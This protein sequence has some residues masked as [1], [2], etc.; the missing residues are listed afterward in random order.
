MEQQIKI[1]RTLEQLAELD[2][3]LEDKDLVAYDTETTGVEKDSKIIGYSI[4]AETHLGWYVILSYWDVEK[5][6]LIDLETRE[7]TKA[8]LMKLKTKSLI[9]HNAVFDCMMTENNWDVS[10]I[11]S[12]HVDTMILAHLVDEN[13]SN[14]LKELGISVFGQDATKEQKEM[15]E[16]VSK[17]GGLLT[18][19]K[20]EL[21]KADAELIARYGAKDAILTLNILFHEFS[22]LQ[23]EGLVDFL[24]EES[25][26]LLRG[27]TY[28]LNTVGLK[29]DMEKLENLKHLLQAECLEAQSFIYSEID[30]AVKQDYPGT[31][32]AKTFNIGS[33]KQ[34]S[35]LLFHKLGNTFATLT[36]EGKEVC[37]ALGFNKLP[38]SDAD[39]RQFLRECASAKGHLYKQAAFNHKT[40]KLGRPKKIG[41]PW[42]Y[43]ACGKETLA[44]LA[45]RYKWVETFLKYAK[46]KK[47]LSTYVEG[48]QSRM[49]YGIIRPSFLQNVVPSGRYASRNPNF[50][51]L[52]RDDKRINACIVSR[53]GKVFVGC[54][55]PQ[56]EPRV[57]ASFSGDKRLLDCFARGEDF[58]SVI[59]MY[60]F[61]KSD[62]VPL[63]EGHPDAFGTKYKTLRQIAKV[64]A[65]SATYGTTAP[66]MAMSIE[67]DTKISK[68]TQE[69]QEIIDNYFE[70]FPAVKQFMNASHQE[71]METGK[72]SS[73]FGRVR[74]IP[75]AKEIKQLFKNVPHSELSYEYR[76]LLNLAVN[77]RIQGTGGSIMNRS[78][79]AFLNKC[80]ELEDKN[81]AWKDV[82]IVLQ[83][84]D[85]LIAEGPENLGSEI[86]EVM[87][88]A[89]SNTVKLPGVALPC[90]PKIAYNLADLK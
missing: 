67:K 87:A 12:V 78:S 30:Q 47:L 81:P 9:M 27:T 59:G 20:Y 84:H 31:S 90:E 35:W 74:R 68:T 56:L 2:K 50:Q 14:A 76:N 58:Y 39:K 75:K 16:S 45:P 54:D 60:A 42:I 32:K 25:M 34:L 41:D 43:L 17:N 4:C 86:V 6:K 57:F 21:Y 51:N 73:L 40:K 46:N 5:K 62:A 64:I 3:Y 83:K 36:D 18:K 44:K 52:P 85:E 28:Q 1:V 71:A 61:A 88:D 82:K 26:P 89:M 70:T 66:K 10:L 22:K 15:K 55:Y 37:K 19:D 24:F 8:L 80:K 72:V 33:S 65:L 77:Y 53:P 69:A 29:V 79:I 48:I 13:R 11:D 49:K 23:D 7:G 63:K 38:Y